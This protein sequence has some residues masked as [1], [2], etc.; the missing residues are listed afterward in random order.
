MS[1][2]SVSDLIFDKF[3]ELVKNDVVFE[4]VA[5]ELDVA[6]RTEKP[7]KADII[8]ILQKQILKAQYKAEEA[9]K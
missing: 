9:A 6:I 1:Q 4:G 3:A 2:K 7:K 5:S 8:K